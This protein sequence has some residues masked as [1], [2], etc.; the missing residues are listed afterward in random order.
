MNETQQWNFWCFQSQ[1]YSLL[2]T[3]C[4]L[5]MEHDPAELQSVSL[6]TGRKQKTSWHVSII[7]YMFILSIALDS[8]GRFCVGFN[9][10]L[11]PLLSC[12][13][14]LKFILQIRTPAGK[15]ICS[16]LHYICC[17]WPLVSVGSNTTWGRMCTCTSCRI[18]CEL[19]EIEPTSM[20]I[21]TRSPGWLKPNLFTF[22][23]TLSLKWL[24]TPLC[25]KCYLGKR[26]QS[27]NAF[28]FNLSTINTDTITLITQMHV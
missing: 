4:D 23:Y 24:V 25:L 18:H 1:T 8:N 3:G 19:D 10:K 14:K 26:P 16:N 9:N 21:F 15:R 28:L 7:F 22:A 12:T 2:K 17:H 20:N 13:S 5:W 6:H 27:S 11:E